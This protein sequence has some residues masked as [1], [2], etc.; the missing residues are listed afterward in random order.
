MW[1]VGIWSWA[2]L[3]LNYCSIILSKLS[4]ASL[5]FIISQSGNHVSWLGC[6]VWKRDDMWYQ[7]P[8]RH[9]I[10]ICPFLAAALIF[11]SYS[12][13][14]PLCLFFL[15]ELSIM[16]LCKARCPVFGPWLLLPFFPVNEASPPGSLLIFRGMTVWQTI[17][18]A[19]CRL[20]NE[21]SSFTSLTV[22]L[23]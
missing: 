7:A 21:P 6:C 10:N 14:L 16:S 11:V 1:E 3:F 13:I 9:S 18:G 8:G 22:Q 20:P 2:R 19:V 17:S 15:A 12:D 4:F 23:I 5:S